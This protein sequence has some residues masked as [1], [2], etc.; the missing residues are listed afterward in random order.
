MKERTMK[1]PRNYSRGG[2]NALPREDSV[3][4]PH[5]SMIKFGKAQNSCF[6]DTEE[7]NHS[8]TSEKVQG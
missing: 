3:S 4:V 7:R 1:T 8:R 2:Y 6:R 5:S